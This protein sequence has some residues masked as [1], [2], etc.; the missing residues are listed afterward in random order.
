M[1]P[2]SPNSPLHEVVVHKY[3]D[4]ALTWSQP[5]FQMV[6]DKT[7]WRT[8]DILRR[9]DD[10]LPDGVGTL[11]K[12]ENRIDD[13]IILSNAHKV[14][15]VHIETLLQ[16]HPLLNGC[17]VFGEGKLNC[18]ILLEPMADSE[19]SEED[20][21]SKVWPDVEHSNFTV[22]EHARVER[23]LVLVVKDNKRFERAAKGTIIRSVC[24]KQYRSEIEDVYEIFESRR[25]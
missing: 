1:E 17:L 19:L 3:A 16:S 13:L 10:P 7:Q 11:W 22:P 15:P 5:A 21:V 18:G 2:I 20:L 25:R 23:G 6:P 9:Y 8:R 14:N 4:P 12:F 24:I